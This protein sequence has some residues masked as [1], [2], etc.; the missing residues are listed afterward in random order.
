MWAAGL[1]PQLLAVEKRVARPLG[2]VILPWQ[3]G[4]RQSLSNGPRYLRGIRSR[5]KKVRVVR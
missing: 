2:E 1:G 5:A 4:N 3:V